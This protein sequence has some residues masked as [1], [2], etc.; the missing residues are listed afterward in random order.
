MTCICGRHLHSSETAEKVVKYTPIAIIASVLLAG[1]IMVLVDMHSQTGNV[2][3]IGIV[4]LIIGILIGLVLTLY[5]LGCCC[6][7][8]E[9]SEIG[10]SSIV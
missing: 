2:F 7:T 9:Y 5:R 8:N 4:L 3:A 6:D 1:F 10:S